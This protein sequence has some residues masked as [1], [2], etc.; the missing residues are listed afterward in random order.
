MQEAAEKRK[1]SPMEHVNEYVENFMELWKKLNIQYDDLEKL[2]N[3][4]QVNEY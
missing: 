1:V 2:T 4:F 3:L